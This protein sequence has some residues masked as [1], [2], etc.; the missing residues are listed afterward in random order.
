MKSITSDSRHVGLVVLCYDEIKIREFPDWDMAV[1]SPDAGLMRLAN[2]Q[3]IDVW[4]NTSVN[5]QK[6]FSRVL[7]ENFWRRVNGHNYN[8]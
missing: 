5:E 7:L 1:R 6:S 8:H 3:T 2:S 4:L